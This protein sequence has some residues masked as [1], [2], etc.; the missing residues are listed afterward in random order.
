MNRLFALIAALLWLALP[1]AKSEATRPERVSSPACALPAPGGVTLSSNTPGSLEVSWAPVV[2]AA[3]Y[4]VSVQNLNAANMVAVLFTSG[5]S[6]T[7]PGI[8]TDGQ[9][10]L[11]QVSATACP[12]GLFG[13]SAQARH[14]PPGYIVIVDDIVIRSCPGPG[15]SGGVPTAPVQVPNNMPGQSEREVL[16]IRVGHE[17]TNAFAEFLIWAECGTTIYFKAIKAHNITRTPASGSGSAI[18]FR[19]T[20]V[21][22]EM[23]RLENGVCDLGV[24]HVSFQANPNHPGDIYHQQTTCNVFGGAACRGG[25]GRQD[26]AQQATA[27]DRALRAAPNPFS[28]QLLVTPGNAVQGA[29][30]LTLFDHAGRQVKQVQLSETSLDGADGF[31]IPTHELPTGMYYLTLRSTTSCQTSRLIKN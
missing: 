11:V 15:E 17:S 16:K 23:L 18:I 2:D 22:K 14:D 8:D 31:V 24:C 10:Y 25:E 4:R 20:I 12:N 1:L 7:I 3:Q 21:N 6:I 13:P 5:T 19:N 28:D 27:M 30:T 9:S 29:A 26:G